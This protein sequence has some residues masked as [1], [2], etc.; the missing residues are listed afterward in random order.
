M[1]SCRETVLRVGVAL[2]ILYL[3]GFL[4]LYY[5][6]RK[7]VRPPED[8]LFGLDILVMAFVVGTLFLTALI[9]FDTLSTQ[10]EKSRKEP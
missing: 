5:S 9:Y 3:T 6:L 10:S 2:V 7:M 1:T 8:V 4:I